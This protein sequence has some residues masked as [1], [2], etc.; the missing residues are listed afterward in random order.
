MRA[1]ECAAILEV[2]SEEVDAL[3]ADKEAVDALGVD[4]EQKERHAA[5]IGTGKDNYTYRELRQ[6]E[7]NVPDAADSIY[8]ALKQFSPQFHDWNYSLSVDSYSPNEICL[9]GSQ[10]ER[11]IDLFLEKHFIEKIG[12]VTI[13]GTDYDLEIFHRG[14]DFNDISIDSLISFTG[15]RKRFKYRTDLPVIVD[16]CV[17]YHIEIAK[18]GLRPI[19]KIESW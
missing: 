5:E 7:F 3:T 8:S 13:H 16:G 10:A 19:E 17:E 9:I 4:D 12:F 18:D 11:N 14:A 2:E 15:K 1:Q 6:V